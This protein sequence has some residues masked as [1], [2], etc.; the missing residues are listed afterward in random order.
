MADE[1]CITCSCNNKD[2]SKGMVFN[3]CLAC[4][5]LCIKNTSIVYMISLKY[6][7]VINYPSRCN[8]CQL[9]QTITYSL[10][11]C[12]EC[13]SNYE[14]IAAANVSVSEDKYGCKSEM[15]NIEY[16]EPLTIYK[17]N[18]MTRKNSNNRA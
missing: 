15:S 8:V 5:N 12:L 11:L 2:N 10:P 6:T 9:E 14:T 3:I 7:N 13:I 18:K 17:L 16:P 1:N 4:V